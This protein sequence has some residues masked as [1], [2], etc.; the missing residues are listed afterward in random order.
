MKKIQK[1]SLQQ[2]KV[3]RS[4]KPKTKKT[5]LRAPKAKAKVSQREKQ[6]VDMQNVWKTEIDQLI[7]QPFASVEEALSTL[8][9]AV[10]ARL[11]LKGKAR[12]ET[13]DYLK[14]LFETDEGLMEELG[15]ILKI[16]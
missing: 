5:L 1:K 10:T 16:K 12:Q 6:S 7:S 4:V 2:V 8:V 9:E 11:G 14:L 3:K 15:Q 13:C